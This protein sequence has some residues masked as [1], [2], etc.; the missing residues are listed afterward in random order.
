MPRKISDSI[1]PAFAKLK[2]TDI[3]RLSPE[4]IDERGRNYY[5]Q[6]RVK[7]PTVQN[8]VMRADV[9]GTDRYRVEIT[10]EGNTPYE[11]EL[12]CDC[13]YQ[14]GICKHVVA[15]LYTWIESPKSFTHSKDK[16]NELRSLNREQLV[17][18]LSNILEDNPELQLTVELYSKLE[19]GRPSDV[20]K[21]K[22][23]IDT[24]F[25]S[26]YIEYKAVPNFIKELRRIRKIAE[27][28]MDG[29]DFNGAF[30]ILVHIVEAC[31][32]KGGMVDDSS[33]RLGEFLGGAVNICADCFPN[34]MN[35]EELKQKFLHKVFDMYLERH[36]V[37][38]DNI[39]DFLLQC[40]KDELDF[41]E[42][43]ALER[44]EEIARVAGSPKKKSHEKYLLVRLLLDI[45]EEMGDIEKY[46]ALCKR[47]ISEYSMM[48]LTEKFIELNRIDEAA[49]VC[50][51]EIKARRDHGYFS[52]A[53][54]KLK[55]EKKH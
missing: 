29:G 23:E 25:S 55:G 41:L 2:K 19:L 54:E 48:N 50:E 33:G 49:A 20:S 3:K 17:K 9:V 30:E 44:L 47:N 7:N 1:H 11:L 16:K 8:K 14:G 46:I 45:Y 4:Q 6:N 34:V 26:D 12:S 13:P 38:E 27:N 5:K 52:D 53:L 35:T 43:H 31:T 39:G 22:K 36:I 24:L 21:I 10:A 18:I 42:K 37:Y 51:D 15:V 32:R 28:I 40:F